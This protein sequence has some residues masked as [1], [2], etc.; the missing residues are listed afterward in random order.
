MGPFAISWARST[1][2]RDLSAWNAEQQIL[3]F[4]S[5]G[6]TTYPILLPLSSGG[7][8]VCIFSWVES[9]T[10]RV[11]TN[12]YSSGSW[13]GRYN[14]AT[15]WWSY[16]TTPGAV[17]DSNNRIWLYYQDNGIKIWY[18]DEPFGSGNWVND[19]TLD[20]S[21]TT[22]SQRL[23]IG[24]N[25]I[26]TI[27]ATSGQQVYY[28]KNSSGTWPNRS[29]FDTLA[30]STNGYASGSKGYD[31][32]YP[33]KVAYEV[34]TGGSNPRNLEFMTFAP[35]PEP[36]TVSTPQAL[37]TTSVRWNFTDNTSNETGFKVHNSSHNIMAQ[38]ATPNLIY[39][40]ETGLS[41]NTQ[42][43]RHIH[44][45][46]DDGDSGPSSSV[47]RYTLP[48]GPDASTDKQINTLYPEG[49]T[50]TFSNENTFGAGG[51]AYY[52]YVW[53]KDN[54]HNFNDTETQWL[55]GTITETPTSDG[56][57]YLHVKSYNGDGVANGTNTY[58]PYVYD[59]TK[60]VVI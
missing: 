50:F 2:P 11:S 28:W 27:F 49:T 4:V 51:V 25:N 35:L 55:S 21:S 38:Q 3:D 44:A 18:G 47:S 14:I 19:G 60:P 12:F 54:T 29:S 40:D 53:D 58:G 43:T 8:I 36:P 23:T 57:W 22:G 5:E 6:N 34:N 42:Y 33:N 31:A 9:G 32:G 24:Q 59:G 37:S 48:R 30:V 39:L 52:R 15:S 1:T 45:Y 17:I 46:N 16:A 7:K 41:A 13:Q 56:N 26:K 20:Q 10:H